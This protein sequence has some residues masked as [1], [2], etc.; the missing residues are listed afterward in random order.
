[1]GTESPFEQQ[2]KDDQSRS[3]GDR[4]RWSLV[5][6]L[7]IVVFCVVGSFSLLVRSARQQK[8]IK[9]TEVAPSGEA[10]AAV[11]N[12][13]GEEEPYERGYS[14]EE[15]DEL[16]SKFD[17]TASNSS[18][19]PKCLDK[20]QR[21]RPTIFL[22]L[23]RSGSTVILHRLNSMTN[24][25]SNT[26]SIEYVGRNPT[27]SLY[28]FDTTI[29]VEEKFAESANQGPIKKMHAEKEAVPGLNNAEHGEWLVNLFCGLQQDHPNELV[30]F[31]WK[32]NFEQF[33]MRTEARE[34]LQL[35]ASLAA[36]AP[37]DQPPI[38]VVRSRRNMLDVQLSNLKHYQ[39]K[40][41]VSRCTKEDEAC[42]D[43]HK[44]A[45][46]VPDVSEFYADVYLKWQY[47]NIIDELLLTLNIPHVYVTYDTLF[48]PDKIVD[49]EEEWNDMLQMISPGAPRESWDEIQDAMPF[50]S[51]SLSRNHME[52]IENG[53]EVYDVFRGT[54]V[55]HLFRLTD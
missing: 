18:I 20:P 3:K 36:K 19:E 8:Q 35:V 32:A 27:E 30:G 24:S 22:S 48:Y 17:E 26:V 13:E 45:L 42:L 52:I 11:D 33:V 29:P 15:F 40:G 4:P 54:E 16:M 6:L 25:L 43:E 1:M 14:L 49:G 44:H 12:D 37:K 2:L 38:A 50:A 23:G 47:E 9:P 39:N 41:L 55:E 21:T 10:E 5:L 53:E 31:K 7:F 28:F 51:T 34:T 46:L